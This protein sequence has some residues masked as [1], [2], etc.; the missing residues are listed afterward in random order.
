MFL[1]L[2]SCSILAAPSWSP[3]ANVAEIRISKGNLYVQLS[4]N[5]LNTCANFAVVNISSEGAPQMFAMVMASFTSGKQIGLYLSDRCD[6]T[7]YSL[8]GTRIR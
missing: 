5:I 2:G 7:Y 3:Y 4:G 1:T 8:L 6:P